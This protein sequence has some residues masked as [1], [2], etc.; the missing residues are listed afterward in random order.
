MEYIFTTIFHPQHAQ[1]RCFLQQKRALR[2]IANVHHIPYH[3]ISTNEMCSHLKILPLPLLNNYFTYI[4]VFKVM[5]NLSPQYI[6]DFFVN[7]D[8]RF[9]KRDDKLKKV[10]FENLN[11]VVATKLNGLPYHIR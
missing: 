1:T 9:P 7:V 4:Y 3:L 2:I 10:P 8:N 6:S 11:H 5:Y